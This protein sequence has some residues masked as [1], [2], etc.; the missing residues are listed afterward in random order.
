MKPQDQTLKIMKN[1]QNTKYCTKKG[2][3]LFFLSVKKQQKISK[4]WKISTG[5]ESAATTFSISV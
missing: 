1:E 3:K 4:L 2:K 5:G